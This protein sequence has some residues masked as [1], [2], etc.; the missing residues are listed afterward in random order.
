MTTPLLRR[1]DESELETVLAHELAH[2]AH[3]DAAVMDV[4]SAPSRVLLALAGVFASVLKTWRI[5][6]LELGGFGVPI[7]VAGGAAVG[8]VPAFLLGWFSDCPCRHARGTW[9]AGR[10]RADAPALAMA[11]ATALA[12]PAANGTAQS[13]SVR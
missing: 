9:Q 12:G 3:R 13:S 7:M 11:N 10:P 8:L 5:T 1:L 2:L 6:V 4:C